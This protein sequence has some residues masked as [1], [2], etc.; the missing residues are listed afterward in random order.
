MIRGIS[1]RSDAGVVGWRGPEGPASEAP[2]ARRFY[3]TPIPFA[4]DGLVLSHI[5]AG[6]AFYR[7][8][9]RVPE[10]AAALDYGGNAL[11]IAN[12]L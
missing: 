7:I 11:G 8:Q 2:A 4:G 3:G 10:D 1:L 5:L 9:F 12:I 6:A